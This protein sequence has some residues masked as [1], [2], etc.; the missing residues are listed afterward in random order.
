MTEWI[1]RVKT[2]GGRGVYPMS[3]RRAQDGAVMTQSDRDPPENRQWWRDHAY[4]KAPD[5]LPLFPTRRV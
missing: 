2:K 5:L 1:A 3:T 4:V